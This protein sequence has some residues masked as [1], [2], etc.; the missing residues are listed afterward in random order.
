MIAHKHSNMSVS[1]HCSTAVGLF[2]GPTERGKCRGFPIDYR[3]GT[4]MEVEAL[5]WKDEEG[6]GEPK[7]LTATGGRGRT[8]GDRDEI[9][10]P[11]LGRKRVPA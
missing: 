2:L 8:T 5:K 4:L 6:E 10:H 11:L 9:N 1:K 7:P 3:L